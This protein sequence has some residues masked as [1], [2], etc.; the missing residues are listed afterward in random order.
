MQPQT[1][2]TQIG[3]A[4]EAAT[5]PSYYRASHFDPAAGRFLSTHR[6]FDL[7]PVLISTRALGHGRMGH[8]LCV[9][10]WGRSRLIRIWPRPSEPSL[11]VLI[12]FLLAS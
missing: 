7:L 4:F 1:R 3:L 8:A 5:N 12:L 10:G 2:R 11:H 6:I 9:K